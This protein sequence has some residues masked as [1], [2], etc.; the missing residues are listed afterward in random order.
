MVF[1]DLDFLLVFLPAAVLGFY[2]V[3]AFA[4]P[5]YTVPFLLFA[6]T[7]FY[8]A[9]N[10]RYLVLLAASVSFNYVLAQIMLRRGARRG[11]ILAMGV[12]CNLG[13]LAFF[14]YSGFFVQT[15]AAVTGQE[16]PGLSHFT[17][18]IVLPLG[19]SF[20]TFQQ[21]AYLID[22]ARHPPAGSAPRE[23][24]LNYSLFVLLFPHL[25]AGPIVRHSEV[26]RQIAALGQRP[27][28]QL[29]AFGLMIFA[30]GLAKKVL[31]ADPLSRI[32][33]RCFNDPASLDML[34]AWVGLL[35]YTFQLYF[36]FSGYSDMAVGLAALFGIVFPQNFD[37]PYLSS[38][39]REF[40][41]RWHITLSNFLRDYLYIP[42]GGHRGS[43]R[44][45]CA[46][47]VFTMLLGGLWHGAGWTFVVWGAYHGVVLAAH[48]LW[49]HWGMRLHRVPATAI[50][51]L[52]VVLGWVWF[53]ASSLEDANLYFVALAGAGDAG[54][55]PLSL[56]E[57][58][59]AFWL[60]PV[61]MAFW[62]ERLP[63]KGR[64]AYF[65][66]GVTGILI[67]LSL[68]AGGEVSEFLYFQF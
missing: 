32:V 58:P 20:F 40:W 29:Q 4:G 43:I 66:A 47:I 63:V 38:D 27:V 36:D 35:S 6:S 3:R 14:K 65:G 33:A 54:A 50:T 60:A 26:S 10:L 51:C 57:L 46:R 59:T 13:L 67:W 55:G 28:D 48:R 8:G 56:N 9:W 17:S 53:R 11:S 34:A 30:V 21:I 7:I 52:A 19:I 12:A 1:S 61:L 41:R 23:P 31:I 68:S 22:T 45:I 5:R 24:F 25:I 18:A 16:A 42:L 15:F 2:A 62:N 37:R 49:R 39:I 44:D 64:Y